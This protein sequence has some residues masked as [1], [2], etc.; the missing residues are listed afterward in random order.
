MQRRTLLVAA[1]AA[2]A[3]GVVVAAETNP[4]MPPALPGLEAL[5]LT[6]AS[7]ATTTLGAHLMPAPT[8]ISFWASWCAPCIAEARYLTRLRT[9]VPAA[10]LNIVG[11][12]IDAP[13]D[14]AELARFLRLVN[15]NYTQLRGDFQTY[16]A[17]NPGPEIALPRLFVFAADGR[18]AAAFGGYPR[19]AGVTIQ[20]AVDAVLA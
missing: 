6:R 13:R 15:A 10:R 3:P 4:A 9:T 5:P 8:V 2:C 18:P 7:G 12:N 16:A 14:E 11:I 20:R 19:G 17:F 1:M